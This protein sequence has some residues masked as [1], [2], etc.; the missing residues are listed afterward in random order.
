MYGILYTNTKV[1]VSILLLIDSG[2]FPVWGYS[3]QCHN[4]SSWAY[5]LVSISTHIVGDTAMSGSA[6]LHVIPVFPF[7]DI[8]Q[9]FSKEIEALS[10]LARHI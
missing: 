10:T 9:L 6:G 7:T 8:V 1:H 3:E 2:L 5:L 4:D